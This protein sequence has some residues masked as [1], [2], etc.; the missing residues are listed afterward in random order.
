[1]EYVKCYKWKCE[2]FATSA[3]DALPPK[4]TCLVLLMW[5]TLHGTF[6]EY[7]VHTFVYLS[8]GGLVVAKSIRIVSG[9][10]FHR[11]GVKLALTSCPCDNVTVLCGM[12]LP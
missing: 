4:F 1:M 6:P 3:L 8:V 9:R 10:F 5:T 2:F 12:C 7:C 11:F